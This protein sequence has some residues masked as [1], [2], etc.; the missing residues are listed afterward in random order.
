[1]LEDKNNNANNMGDE[2]SRTVINAL[3]TNSGNT[4]SFGPQLATANYFKHAAS[5]ATMAGSFQFRVH[6]LRG[7]IVEV[8]KVTSFLVIPERGKQDNFNSSQA[9]KKA[10]CMAFSL[11]SVLLGLTKSLVLETMR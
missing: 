6:V 9:T 2:I 5:Y 4:N 7:P 8:L 1:M 10:L 11:R 3:N